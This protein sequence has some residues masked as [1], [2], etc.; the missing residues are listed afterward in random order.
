MSSRWA[1]DETYRWPSDKPVWTLT[2][3]VL[4]VLAMAATAFYQYQRQWMFLQQAYL[5]TYISTKR[6]WLK[7]APYPILYRVEW[8]TAASGSGR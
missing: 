7:T 4:S 5:K 2:V 1:R 6:T 8:Q 3:L